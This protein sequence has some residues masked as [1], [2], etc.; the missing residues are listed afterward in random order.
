[1]H[2]AHGDWHTW[3]AWMFPRAG[4]SGAQ[5]RR[6]ARTWQ[7]AAK[8][9]SRFGRKS[10]QSC[11]P[12]SAKSRRRRK[13]ARRCRS[14]RACMALL[15]NGNCRRFTRKLIPLGLNRVILVAIP[16]RRTCLRRLR[17]PTS[18]PARHVRPRAAT[19]CLHVVAGWEH[20]PGRRVEALPGIGMARHGKSARAVDEPRTPCRARGW[21]CPESWMGPPIAATIPPVACGRAALPHKTA[22]G[23][24]AVTPPCAWN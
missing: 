12:R 14:C 7:V 23:S 3:Q 15:M 5:P 22:T 18:H 6:S 16:P 2:L 8:A 1:M 11:T 9:G 13:C 24:Q 4:D 17:M 19:S 10:P 20:G 21:N